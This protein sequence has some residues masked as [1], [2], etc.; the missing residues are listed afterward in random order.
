M[1][2]NVKKNYKK[3]CFDLIFHVRDSIFN[4]VQ[5]EK[6]WMIKDYGK[7]GRNFPEMAENIC[8]YSQYCHI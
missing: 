1:I 6:I 5:K 8:L 2:P 3:I 7:S 4:Y